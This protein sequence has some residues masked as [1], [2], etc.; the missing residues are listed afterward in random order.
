VIEQIL[1]QSV[2]S[3]EARSD[4]LTAVL[5]AAEEASVGRAV[6]K[7]RSEFTT[8]RACARQ[9]LVRLGLPES[10]ITNG[11]HGE[12]QWP[13]GVV[14]SITHCE[15]YRAAALARAGEITTI[16]IDAEP[17][18]PLPPG[19]PLDSVADHQERHALAELRRDVKGVHWDRLLF[20]AKES[21]YKAWFPLAHR[22]LNFEDARVTI[23]PAAGTFRARLLV[24]GP[25]VDG[26]PLT[27]FI[28][29]WSVSDGVILT[30]ITHLAQTSRP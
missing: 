8:A 18:R 2:A 1:P 10:P 27:G 5:F 23:D 28:G 22:W 3:V 30:A 21:I 4:D 24:A 25:T 6:E 17:H 15:G 7:R 16:G 29:R 14:G 13:A 12:P 11:P 9:A 19:V 26:Q 20:S